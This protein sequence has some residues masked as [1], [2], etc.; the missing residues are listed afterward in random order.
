LI[1]SYVSMCQNEVLEFNLYW[2]SDFLCANLAEKCGVI[3]VS[4]RYADR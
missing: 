3:K 4:A 2:F 1:K